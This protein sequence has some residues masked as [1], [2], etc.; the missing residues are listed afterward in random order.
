MRVERVAL[1]ASHST[2]SEELIGDCFDIWYSA[3]RLNLR[4][5]LET[6][7]K[8]GTG[9]MGGD[10]ESRFSRLSRPSRLSQASAIA[11]EA[12]VSTAS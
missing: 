6:C 7:E 8:S 1:L 11:A 9:K 12:S 2:I 3:R 5:T 10:F 4:E